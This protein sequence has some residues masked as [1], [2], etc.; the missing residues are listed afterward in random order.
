[1]GEAKFFTVTTNAVQNVSRGKIAIQGILWHNDHTSTMFMQIFDVIAGNVVLGTTVPTTVLQ[2]GA[3]Q[4]KDF[5]FW[6]AVFQT[7]FSFA[8]T[9]TRSGSTAAGTHDVTVVVQ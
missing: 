2:L 3:D 8:I 7:A 5:P 1:M 6:D 4:V 9:D